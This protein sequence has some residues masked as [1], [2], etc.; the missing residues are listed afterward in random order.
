[1]A[2]VRTASATARAAWIFAC[3]TSS[4]RLVST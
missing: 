2:L 1:M 3:R 4:R